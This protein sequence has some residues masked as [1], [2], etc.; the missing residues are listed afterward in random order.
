M[1][2]ATITLNLTREEALQLAKFLPDKHTLSYEEDECLIAIREA[3]CEVLDV[4]PWDV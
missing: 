3:L 2:K 4:K 1:S